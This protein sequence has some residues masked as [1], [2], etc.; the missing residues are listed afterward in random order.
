MLVV[1]AVNLAM[2]EM[3]WIMIVMMLMVLTAM[4]TI[5]IMV[6]VVILHLIRGVGGRAR[7][8]D[9]PLIVS[10]TL[11]TL[12]VQCT[13][14]NEAHTEQKLLFTLLW[15]TMYIHLSKVILMYIQIVMS[16]FMGCAIVLR[17]IK[18]LCCAV[19]F[20]ELCP[21]HRAITPVLSLLVLYL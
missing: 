17:I 14:H 2:M 18:A 12:Y 21:H 3:M 15:G 16:S 11:F 8:P 7:D 10:H 9:C 1:L 6:A 13:I 19:L 4:I 5:M 20:S